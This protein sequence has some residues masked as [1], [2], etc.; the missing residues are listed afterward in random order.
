[1]SV[2]EEIDK[3][4]AT[5][6]VRCRDANIQC[7]KMDLKS[8]LLADLRG[9]EVFLPAGRDKRG[10]VLLLS[11]DPDS[12]QEITDVLA[13]DFESYCFLHGYEAICRDEY[14]YIEAAIAAQGRMRTYSIERIYSRLSGTP[15]KGLG[16]K[17]MS[18]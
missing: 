17:K 13:L 16:D 10:I 1:M 12:L 8:P 14:T 7:E 9:Y 3:A 15:P 6:L 4:I 18:P 11:D 5:L 2:R